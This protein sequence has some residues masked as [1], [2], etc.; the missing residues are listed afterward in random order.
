MGDV[1]LQELRTMQISKTQPLSKLRTRRLLFLIRI[2][3]RVTGV[4]VTGFTFSVTL[5]GVDDWYAA[6][7]SLHLSCDGICVEI[8]AI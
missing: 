4:A 1:Q 5:V 8:L 7:Q 2:R 3:V 6:A